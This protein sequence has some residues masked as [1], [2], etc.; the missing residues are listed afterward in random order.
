MVPLRSI[1]YTPL[2]MPTPLSLSS[3][4]DQLDRALVLRANQPLMLSIAGGGVSD[5]YGSEPLASLK[6]DR[7]SCAQIV[8]L[9]FRAGR[10]S[11]TT[12][13]TVN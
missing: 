2:P 13:T 10:S 3:P 9:S 7:K 8:R 4:S 5:P 1:T 12:T 6:R 11:V